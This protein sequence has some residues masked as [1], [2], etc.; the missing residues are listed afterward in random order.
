MQQQ[1]PQQQRAP[2]LEH[3]HGCAAAAE[4]AIAE[5]VAAEEAAEDA[6]AAVEAPGNA[7]AKAPAV[8]GTVTAPAPHRIVRRHLERV[9][10]HTPAVIRH[11]RRT[12][13]ESTQRRDDRQ[14]RRCVLALL[15][16]LCPHHEV[17]L[18]VQCVHT[19]WAEW[20]H[21]RTTRSQQRQLR[22]S[23][24]QQQPR[25]WQRRRSARSNRWRAGAHDG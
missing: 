5:V 16:R 1:Q 20:R 19:V 2:S 14:R 7:P 11:S 9:E 15:A 12:A 22:L 25:R 17:G 18:R 21:G 23:V 6:S 13:I 4:E 10:H 24:Q 8:G 3:A